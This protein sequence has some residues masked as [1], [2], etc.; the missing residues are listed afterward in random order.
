MISNK[1]S[2]KTFIFCS[3][4]FFLIQFPCSGESLPGN[5]EIENSLMVEFKEKP[6]P[7]Q[8]QQLLSIGKKIKAFQFDNY[9]SSYFQRL[10]K[11]IFSATPEERESIKEK[12]Q[13]LNFV[14]KVEK[15]YGI[16]ASQTV[17][18]ATDAIELTND[19]LLPY[20]WGLYNNGQTIFKDLDDIHQIEILGVPSVDI[21]IFSS[22]NLIS[23]LIKEDVV[24]AVLDHGADLE[25]PDLKDNYFRNPTECN[26]NG[27]P[28]FNPQ[29]DN[30]GNGYKGDCLGW[31]FST[32]TLEGDNRPYDDEGHGT[33]IAGIIAAT[34]NNKRGI[35][36]LSNR[37]KILPIKVLRKKE[38]SRNQGSG[39]ITLTDRIA[40]GIL[41][42]IK[43]GVKVVNLSLGW[44]SVLDTN[45][46]RETIREA[47]NQGITIIA[48]AGNNGNDSQIF[49]CAYPEV[50]CVGAIEADGKI[51]R[52][53]NYG[54]HVDL[55]APGENILSTYPRFMDP[56][57]FSIKGYEIKN[58]TSQAAPFISAS[59]AILKGINPHISENEV[60]AR[61]FSTAKPILE[62][63]SK[64]FLNGLANIGKAVGQKP[65][66]VIR[67]LFKDLRPFSVN[68]NDGTFEFPLTFKNFWLDQENPITIQVSFEDENIN[69][70]KSELTLN[71]LKEGQ[72]LSLKF[73]GQFQTLMGDSNTKTKISLFEGG[74]LISSYKTS[75][76]FAI[77]AEDN[78]NFKNFPLVAPNIPVNP[79]TG[80]PRLI[81]VS[82]PYFRKNTPIYFFEEKLEEGLKLHFIK[83]SDNTFSEMEEAVFLPKAKN[84]ISLLT[85]DANYDG[86]PDFFI[87]SLAKDGEKSYLQYSYYD[88]NL[89]PLFKKIPLIKFFPETTFLNFKKLSFIS[90]LPKN[91]PSIGKMA[92]PIF[93]EEAGI[94]KKDQSLDPWLGAN[95]STE[96]HIFYLLPEIIDGEWSFTTRIIDND[97]W[98]K[99]LKKLLTLVWNDKIN[100]LEMVPQS[101]ENFNKGKAQCL[102]SVGKNFFTKLMSI[103]L[104]L[105]GIP[106]PSP[107]RENK[108]HFEGYVYLTVN[109]LTK[110]GPIYNQSILG[111]GLLN[112]HTLYLSNLAQT[113]EIPG[114]EVN[115]ST[116]YIQDSYTDNILG[117]LAA[118]KKNGDLITFFQ[119]KGQ[120]KV[121]VQGTDGK[122]QIGSRPI[123]RFSFLPGELFSETFY[124]II[125]GSGENA[126]PALYV[127]T[128]QLTTDAVYILTLD[129]FDRPYSPLKYNIIIPN[130]C[131]PQNPTPFGKGGYFNFILLCKE[132][133]GSEFKLRFM[134]IK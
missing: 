70:E 4:I 91:I 120:L 115:F 98:R 32:E 51:T 27:I 31:N 132:G 61:L 67:P 1:L 13:S 84:I 133:S 56:E 107:I 7:N 39:S 116:T 47:Q 111:A 105:D 65:I 24:V 33:H 72:S 95:N 42:A 130:N 37:I 55:L 26:E 108:S 63:D 25:H 104:N 121:H 76:R 45:Y 117:P 122:V 99:E 22:F 82:D 12:I 8:I 112:S 124:P 81:T 77:K 79:K 34:S 93:M 123:Q 59:V 73:K 92:I 71:P 48:A 19:L 100:F 10:Y 9:P 78:P 20:Q 114:L 18:P 83:F 85:L 62:E 89:N 109:E 80:I 17:K 52:F 90:F 127:D 64:F 119:T 58:G 69:L 134:E 21:G 68:P 87:S 118:Y 103:D 88:E 113:N 41:Y 30:D 110:N 125:K 40:K 23:S 94:P 54:G 46:L 126:I 35:T 60:K 6:N 14:L 66:S 57:H 43:R 128:T 38:N 50:I 11:I 101:L 16:D 97:P 5:I 44:P 53:S 75:L 15:V 36:G 2:L 86:K 3:L 28:P 106:K 49:P 129:E 74:K 96:N 102:V 29:N 131:I